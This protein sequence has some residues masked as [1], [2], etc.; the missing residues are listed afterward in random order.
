MNIA[1]VVRINYSIWNCMRAFLFCRR[2]VL[3]IMAFCIGRL[4][5]FWGMPISQQFDEIKYHNMNLLVIRSNHTEWLW[6]QS[7]VRPLLSHLI[8]PSLT[9]SNHVWQGKQAPS[10]PKTNEEGQI[11]TDGK[12][13]LNWVRGTGLG[14]W[15]LI[16]WYERKNR[17]ME[18][19]HMQKIYVRTCMHTLSHI[20]R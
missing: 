20:D 3:S 5:M 10:P 1:C 2:V 12:N 16:D 17:K 7:T 9:V 4:N 14:E 13:D 6:P 15:L 8:M 18:N 19:D 11:I